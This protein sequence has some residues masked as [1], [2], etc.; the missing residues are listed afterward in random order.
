M[1]KVYTNFVI[2]VSNNEGLNIKE[3]FN[4]ETV[5]SMD[6]DVPASAADQ[7]IDLAPVP[8]T[9]LKL[10]MITSDTYHASD[11]T[12]KVGADTTVRKLDSPH[13]FR[14]KGQAEFLP[15]DVSKLLVSNAM[16]VDVKLKILVLWDTVV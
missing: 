6:V 5:Q 2:S 14:G 11:L 8:N 9:G 15:S 3:E 4:C 12:Y 13:I 10:L 1:Q 16:A 7:E